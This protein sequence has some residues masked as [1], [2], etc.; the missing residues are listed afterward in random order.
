MIIKN[1]KDKTRKDLLN[2]EKLR[3]I[4]NRKKMILKLQKIFLNP[5][6]IGKKRLKDVKKFIKTIHL[7]LTREILI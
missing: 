7:T 5:K 2:K 1:N 3:L 6:N 4:N